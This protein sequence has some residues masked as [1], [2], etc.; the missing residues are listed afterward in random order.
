[1]DSS[2][3]STDATVILDMNDKCLVEVFRHL[4][5]RDFCAVAEV[6]CRFEQNARTCFEL[7]NKSDLILMEDVECDG[8]SDDEVIFK[9]SK[10]LH[11]FGAFFTK[12]DGDDWRHTHNPQHWMQKSTAESQLRI[13]ELLIRYCSGTLAE[14]KIF[15]IQINNE[16]VPLMKPL[17]EGLHILEMNFI[18]TCQVFFDML[19]L[20]STKLKKLK[21][22][23][24]GD[25]SGMLVRLHQPF[26][27]MVEIDLWSV[28]G[29]TNHDFEEMLRHNPQLKKITLDYGSKLD[30]QIV[31]SIA[32]HVP[33]VECL[34]IGGLLFE[35]RHVQHF[36]QKIMW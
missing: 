34:H 25:S 35:Q 8:D 29:L 18:L 1:M 14:L 2:P 24:R 32:N 28:D 33:G 23:L 11:R 36:G 19:P 7:S 15:G 5:L 12:F 10:I 26:R 21:L 4:S 16:M 3:S 6:C 20:L 31:Q 22:A 27:E 13:F 17:L 9:V 30:G